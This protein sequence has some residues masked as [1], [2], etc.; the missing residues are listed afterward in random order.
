VGRDFVSDS[1]VPSIGAHQAHDHE[2]RFLGRRITYFSTGIIFRIYWNA[3]DRWEDIN[4]V[5]MRLEWWLRRKFGMGTYTVW[6]QC[7]SGDASG[8]FY[9]CYSTLP[10]EA[11]A[12]L[13]RIVGVVPDE[14]IPDKPLLP[15]LEV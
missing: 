4:G 9:Q 15:K 5:A 7:A 11:D 12:E 1:V 2:F 6:S 10:F 13:R 3:E 8:T 14:D